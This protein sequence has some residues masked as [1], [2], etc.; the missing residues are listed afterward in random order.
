MTKLKLQGNRVGG[1]GAFAGD[2]PAFKYVDYE[3]DG[4]DAV[5]GNLRDEYGNLRFVWTG[6]KV[7]LDPMTPT[8]DQKKAKEK[9]D[10]A[11][12]LRDPDKL[13]E[14][15]KKKIREELKNQ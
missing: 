7:V 8:A 13:D 15:I 3:W 10:L 6:S 5:E 4:P 14:Y 2:N 11:M 12:E 1:F 9:R